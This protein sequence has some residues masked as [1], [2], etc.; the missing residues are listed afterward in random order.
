MKAFHW[1]ITAF[2]TALLVVSCGGAP[3]P[4]APARPIRTTE[5]A[6]TEEVRETAEVLER[7]EPPEPPARAVESDTTVFDPSSI[8]KEEFDSTKVDVQQL[9]Q[10]L[11]GIIKAKNYTGWVSYLDG[12]YFRL[13]SSREYLDR[14]NKTDRMRK[15]NIVLYNA[16]DYFN[17]VVVPSRANDRVDDIE[18]VSQ[19]R[20]KAYTVSSRGE[21]LRL[22]D[23]EKTGEGWKIIN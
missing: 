7:P 8:T 21:R 15:A 14:I 6:R 12:D 16:R 3:E 5:P 1:F 13:I 17:N 4:Q 22:Y 9:I 2:L 19:I 18:F 23:L 11:N 10:K 20:V